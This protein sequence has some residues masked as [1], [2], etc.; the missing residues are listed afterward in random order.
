MCSR[1]AGASVITLSLCLA[2]LFACGQGAHNPIVARVADVPIRKTTLATWARAIESG[3]AAAPADAPPRA[4]ARE[5]A[6]DYLISAHWMIGEAAERGLGTPMREV[7]RGVSQR[8]EAAPMG[9][10]EFGSESKQTI[11]GLELEVR[12]ELAAARLR[13]LV[14]RQVAP[15]T[16]AEVTD[17]YK[18]HLAEFRIRQQRQ[19]DLV[20][21]LPSRSAAVALGRRLGTG[22]RFASKAAHELVPSTPPYR[23]N[24]AKFNTGLL[25]VIFAAR[26]G[27][28]TGP[29]PFNNAW[30][31]LVVRRVEPGEYVALPDVQALITKRLLERHRHAALER[32]A[33]PYRAKWTARTSCSAGFVVAKCLQYHGPARAERDPL[34][35]SR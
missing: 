21:N 16:R 3:S 14:A 31:L 24:E 12:T 22:G 15:V 20:E 2:G 29:V 6:L 27:K 1:H 28:L 13:A 17:Y 35:P 19:V 11:S 34:A 9:R 10:A 4:S 33:G 7:Q 23:A 8:I 5:R 26:P 25:R 30:T 32:F 18:R